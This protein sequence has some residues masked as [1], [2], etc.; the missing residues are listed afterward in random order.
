M[1]GMSVRTSHAR[2]I[3]TL[4]RNSLSRIM[5]LRKVEGGL[6]QWWGERV[7]SDA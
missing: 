1:S 5:F 7:E 2:S 6:M 4:T 3:G